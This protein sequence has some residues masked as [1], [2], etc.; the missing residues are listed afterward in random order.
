M[1][2]G[3][4]VTS[5]NLIRKAGLSTYTE[6]A[7]AGTF[8]ANPGDVYEIVTGIGASDDDDEPFGPKMTY[9]VPCESYATVSAQLVDYTAE[10]SVT[11]RFWDSEDGTVIA[12]AAPVDIDNGDV[13]NLKGELQA[14]FEQDYGNRFCGKG[15]VFVVKYMTGNFTTIKLTDIS[16]NQYPQVSIPA[17]DTDGASGYT[18]KAFELPVLKSNEILT[19]YLVADASGAGK[20]P[21]GSN[22]NVTYS[23]YDSDFFI[24]NDV[25]PPQVECGVTDEDGADIGSAGAATGTIYITQAS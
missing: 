5:K 1:Y 11:A 19:F 3:A 2:G 9:T 12:A 24:N 4:A 17:L 23:L 20:D 7:G 25:N 21:S 13:F 22:A 8:T 6:V 15:N 14:V 18:Q 16:G 10:G